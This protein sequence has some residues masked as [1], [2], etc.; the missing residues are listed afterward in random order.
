MT[1][2][3]KPAIYGKKSQKEG[4]APAIA[5]INPKFPHNVGATVRAASCFG[6]K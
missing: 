4:Q 2:T 6:I 5:L 3:I 1:I